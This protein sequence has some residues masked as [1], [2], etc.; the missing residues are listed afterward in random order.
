MVPAVHK[1][2]QAD[3]RARQTQNNLAVA[4]ALAWYQR[5]NGRYPEKLEA[6]APKYLAKV[7]QDRFSG[8]PLVYRP[9][10]KGYLLYSVGVNGKDEGGRT[11]SDMPPGDDL[12]VRMSAPR[13]RK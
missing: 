2:Q 1:V 6:L 13:P 11:Y 10:D 5:V 12:P 9:A 7:P 4:F 3:D 8:K